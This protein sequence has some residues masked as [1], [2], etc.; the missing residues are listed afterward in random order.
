M[1][2][3][4]FDN[5]KRCMRIRIH[6]TIRVGIT[7][8]LMCI[9]P[10]VGFA[11]HTQI[12]NTNITSASISSEQ[13]VDIEIVSTLPQLEMG[14]FW[15]VTAVITNRSDSTIYL[16][17]ESLIL[18]IPAKMGHL[19]K[20][21][22]FTATF[23]VG[24]EGILALRPGDNSHVFWRPENG[25]PAWRTLINPITLLFK[26]GT[27]PV[28]ITGKYW[29]TEATD[30]FYRTITTSTE[31]DIN[32]FMLIVLFGAAIGGIGGM[33][34]RAIIIK[35]PNRWDPQDTSKDLFFKSV[36]T[37]GRAV[38]MISFSVMVTI[39]LYRVSDSQLLFI[40]IT[41]NDF[42]GGNCDW[43]HCK[44]ERSEHPKAINSLSKK[45]IGYR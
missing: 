17:E 7:I 5:I 2:Q 26:P 6:Q 11:K 19:K 20:K 43:I 3:Y 14:E 21:W 35:G 10:I 31:L 28:N 24:S 34:I 9:V 4:I 29:Q 40:S 41:V 8:G 13:L 37:L 22:D 27:Y 38:L 30:R 36:N 32:V 18:S 15:G 45:S 44:H 1:K 33:V 39:L 23:P 42:W 25:Y 16:K 12:T